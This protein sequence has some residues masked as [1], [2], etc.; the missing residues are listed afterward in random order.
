MLKIT[1]T[2]EAQTMT[3]RVTEEGSDL[4]VHCG[5]SESHPGFTSVTIFAPNRD[6]VE[7]IIISFFAEYGEGTRFADP[8]KCADGR[9]GSYG[10]IPP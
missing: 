10:R 5:P 1:Y 4:E 6:D 9:W 7:E 8:A 2:N 3:V